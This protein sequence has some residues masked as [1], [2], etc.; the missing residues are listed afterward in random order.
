LQLCGGYSQN[1]DVKIRLFAFSLLWAGSLFGQHRFNWQDY[2]FFH[3]TAPFCFGHDFAIKPNASNKSATPR[4]AITDST[5]WVPIPEVVTPSVIVV[6]GIDWRFADP[7]ADA[8]VGFNVS[9]LWASPLARS[10]IA[11][12]GAIQGLT[13]A[14]SEKIFEG[15]SG[16][17]RVALSLRNDQIV[18]MIT[19]HLADSSFPTLAAGWRAVPVAGKGV[20]VGHAEA[21]DQAVQRMAMEGPSAE[22]TRLAEGWQGDREF[23]AVG[24]ARLAGPQAV[25]AGMNRFSLAVSIRDR[26]TSN[27]A[28]EFNEVLDENTRR[29]WPAT[30]AGATVEGRV[31]RVKMPMEADEVRQK[32]GE[33]AASPLGQQLA[34]LVTAARYLPSRDIAAKTKPV[35]YGLDK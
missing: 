19:G 27:A 17:Y 3:S 15:L 31:V 6:G 35:I 5:P 9:G 21:V 2:C 20:L 16:V 11:Q 33:L 32:L 7:L 1:R 4:S 14:D 8:L 26:L 23:W 30:L 22:V 34:D 13:K 12:L 28:F 24:S 29:M 18:I 25:N 10:L